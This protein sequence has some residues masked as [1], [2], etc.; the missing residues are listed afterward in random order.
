MCSTIYHGGMQKTDQCDLLAHLSFRRLERQ[1]KWNGTGE[2]EHGVA[3]KRRRCGLIRRAASSPSPESPPL[4]SIHL[5]SPHPSTRRYVTHAHP[6]G[7]AHV[8]G[9]PSARARHARPR[10]TSG[11]RAPRC[12]G[13]RAAHA[14]GGS[15]EASGLQH[16]GPAVPVP[17]RVPAVRRN[18]SPSA[19]HIRSARD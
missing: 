4:L 12:K 7:C 18:R 10:R 19:S 15:S 9:D 5:T 11:A 17:A 3:R 2:N 6:A 16:N 14:P 13:Q 8:A 1:W